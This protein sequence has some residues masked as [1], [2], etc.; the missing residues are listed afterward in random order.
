MK[1][2]LLEIVQNILS[3]MDAE[4]VSTIS[5]TIESLQVAEEV[6]T[7]YYENLGAWKVPNRVQMVNME[8]V[9]D[10]ANHPH[11]LKVPDNIVE[12]HWLRYNTQTVADPKYVPVQYCSP[13][14]FLERVL[15]NTSGDTVTHINNDMPYYIQSNKNPEY[16][17]IIDNEHILFD[18]YNSTLDASIQVSKCMVYAEATPSWTSSD[19]F[20]PDLPA[21]YFPM[22]LAEAKSASFIN[23]KG[24]ANEKEEQRSRRQKVTLQNNQSRV[25][26]NEA[27]TPDF[28]RS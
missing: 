8:S 6:K 9:A 4:E 24:V 22:L 2:T 5:D 15:N 18:S 20:I 17:T 19:D 12:I 27:N 16:W 21:N 26:Q 13:E 11:A 3:S 14:D 10:S 25:N 28:G 23:Y 1:M 7:T